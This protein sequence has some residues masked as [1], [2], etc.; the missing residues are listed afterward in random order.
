MYVCMC[1]RYL[2][3]NCCCCSVQQY[4]LIITDVYLVH[5][6]VQERLYRLRLVLPVLPW[7]RGTQLSEGRGVAIVNH[8]QHNYSSITAIDIKVQI[9]VWIS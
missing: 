9:L 5:Q 8:A 3:P 7:P 6:T 4:K 2:V 1:V